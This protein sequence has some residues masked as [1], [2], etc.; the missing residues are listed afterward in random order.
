MIPSSWPRIQTHG[1]YHSEAI[2][3]ELHL[4]NI[5]REEGSP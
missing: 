4:D 5:N 3:I 2:K 1:M